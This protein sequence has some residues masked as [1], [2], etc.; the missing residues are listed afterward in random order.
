MPPGESQMHVQV[1]IIVS[2]TW[3]LWW[4]VLFYFCS[5]HFP[6]SIK[7]PSITHNDVSSFLIAVIVQLVLEVDP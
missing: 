1:P 6:K 4:P 5:A 2:H 3:G 7:K